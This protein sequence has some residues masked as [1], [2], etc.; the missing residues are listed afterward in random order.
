VVV[1]D[2]TFFPISLGGLDTADRLPKL[3]PF[4]RDVEAGGLMSY[5]PDQEAAFRRAAAYVDRILRGANPADLPVE[6]PTKFQFAVN[7][8]TARA[9]NLTIAPEL[10]ARADAVIE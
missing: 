10:L 5:G 2:C 8:T 3:W 1:F 7:L 6:E 9:M 4:F